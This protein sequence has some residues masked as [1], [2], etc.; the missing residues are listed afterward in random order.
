M[1][2]RLVVGALLSTAIVSVGYLIY[3]D[4]KR[5]DPKFRQK[6]KRDKREAQEE[7]QV[8]SEERAAKNAAVAAASAAASGMQLSEQFLTDLENEPE[9]KTLEEKEKYFIKHLDIGEKLLAKGT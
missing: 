2:T 9:P 1:S 6:I 4:H 7:Y 8:K 3:F 5:R